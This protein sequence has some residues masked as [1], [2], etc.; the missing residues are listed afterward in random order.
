MSEKEERRK[1]RQQHPFGIDVGRVQDTC[2]KLHAAGQISQ[3]YADEQQIADAI[4]V[5]LAHGFVEEVAPGQ[6]VPGPNHPGRAAFMTRHREQV[7]QVQ[8][9]Q[10]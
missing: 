8:G 7:L 2:R 3:P 4:Q 6:Y 10:N 5:A 9:Q 1:R